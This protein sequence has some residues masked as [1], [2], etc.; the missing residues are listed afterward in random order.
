MKIIIHALLVLVLSCQVAW[1]KTEKATIG[2]LPFKIKEITAESFGSDYDRDFAPDTQFRD[3]ILKTRETLLKKSSEDGAGPYSL[4]G[5]IIKKLTVSS[6]VSTVDRADK[7]LSAGIAPTYFYSCEFSFSKI[8]GVKDDGLYQI[9]ITPNCHLIN[10]Q[11]NKDINVQ[12][13]YENFRTPLTTRIEDLDRGVAA[14]ADSFAFKVAGWIHH[15]IPDKRELI[16]AIYEDLDDFDQVGRYIYQDEET[17]N[18][19]DLIADGENESMLTFDMERLSVYEKPLREFTIEVDKGRFVDVPEITGKMSEDGK[20]V[21]LIFEPSLKRR[22]NRY[23]FNYLYKTFDCALI[24]EEPIKL[25][26]SDKDWYKVFFTVKLSDMLSM[27]KRNFILSRYEVLLQCPPATH[28][29]ADVK[30]KKITKIQTNFTHG[31]ERTP[32]E[33]ATIQTTKQVIHFDFKNQRIINVPLQPFSRKL[34]DF[35]EYKFNDKSCDM[36]LTREITEDAM[37]ERYPVLLYFNEHGILLRPE[38]QLTFNLPK[39]IK[40]SFSE[41]ELRR[42]GFH[43]HEKKSEETPEIRKPTITK[44]AED[45]LKIEA[46]KHLGRTAADCSNLDIEVDCMT[47]AFNEPR[48]VDELRPIAILTGKLFTPELSCREQY[49]LRYV[50]PRM[51]DEGGNLPVENT[52]EEYSVTIRRSTKAEIKL[53]EKQRRGIHQSLSAKDLATGNFH[54][55]DSLSDDK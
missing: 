44:T 26:G 46:I 47:D 35:E 16:D 11:K 36:E 20:K 37:K 41:K 32:Y 45:N 38:T 10:A 51:L 18:E 23:R 12:F 6:I 39:G 2:I 50:L 40:V 49:E 30:Y 55:Y 5:G 33:R 21:Q 53:F 27:R 22:G 4:M 29:T 14:E 3:A 24:D 15:S 54:G 25:A 19:D 1:A 34:S 28:F 48:V 9:V 43:F 8:N 42:S 31:R 13:N 52:E 7:L 17:D